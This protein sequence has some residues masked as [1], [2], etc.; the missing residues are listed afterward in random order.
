VKLVT[1]LTRLRVNR[2][3]VTQGLYNLL[4]KALKF[5]CDG[6]PQDVEVAAYEEARVG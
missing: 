2:P 5:T 3:C 6:K 1:P 4:T